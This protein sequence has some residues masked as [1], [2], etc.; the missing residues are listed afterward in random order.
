MIAL[1]KIFSSK[2]PKNMAMAILGLRYEYPEKQKYISVRY[3]PRTG[4]VEF[5]YY[6]SRNKVIPLHSL[7]P[8]IVRAQKQFLTETD[9]TPDIIGEWVGP[10]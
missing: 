1:H 6:H 9:L 7:G 3:N 8:W 10:E 5:V 2:I 4:F